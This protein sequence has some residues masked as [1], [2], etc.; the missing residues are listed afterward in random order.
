[1]ALLTDE[2]ARAYA[3]IDRVIAST[4]PD[5]PAVHA[6]FLFTWKSTEYQALSIVEVKGNLFGAGGFTP[7]GGLTVSVRLDAFGDADAP[8]PEPEQFITYKS[9]RYR[10]DITKP[11]PDGSGLMII[12]NDPNRGAGIVERE[13]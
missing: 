1:M 13:M 10:I 4:D 11:T 2:I 3:E 12:C 6:N 9:H 8:V 5:N 7:D